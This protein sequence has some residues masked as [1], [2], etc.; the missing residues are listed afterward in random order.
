MRLLMLSLI[1]HEIY[2]R[3]VRHLEMQ[4]MKYAIQSS[5]MSLPLIIRLSRIQ[6]RSDPVVQACTLY[7]DGA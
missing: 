5:P 6:S 7:N 3:P 2:N 1:T 4:G